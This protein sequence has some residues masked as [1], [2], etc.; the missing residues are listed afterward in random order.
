MGFGGY[1]L[2]GL[3]LYITRRLVLGREGF[4]NCF[5]VLPKK[6]PF[7]FLLFG[8]G[9]VAIRSPQIAKKRKKCGN[10][11]QS[12]RPSFRSLSLGSR[13]KWKLPRDCFVRSSSSPNHPNQ[14][15]HQLRTSCLRLSDKAFATRYCSPGAARSRRTVGKDETVLGELCARFQFLLRSL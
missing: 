5:Y 1:G 4:P 12:V 13:N 3:R 10:G 14:P 9:V 11:N 8:G 15:F 2:R 6:V 7:S